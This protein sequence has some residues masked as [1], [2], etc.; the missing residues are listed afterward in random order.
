MA[1]AV[2]LDRA[3]IPAMTP[4][5][6]TAAQRVVEGGKLWVTGIP[7]L[8][9]EFSG[10]AGGM[11]MIHPLGGATPAAK[12][13]VLDFPVSD[14]PQTPGEA[15]VIRFGA[16]NTDTRYIA[17]HADEAAISPSLADALSGWM[18][19]GELVAALT[20]LGK[21]PV[22]FETIGAY[23]GYARMA[24]YNHGETAF[25]DD[26][27]VPP[28]AAGTLANR[29]ADAVAAMLHRVEHEQRDNLDRAGVWAREAKAQ[30]KRLILYSMGHLFPDEIGKTAIGALFHSDGWNAGFHGPKPDDTYH[31]G[32][33]VVLI[34]YQQPP[35]DL[36][37]KARPAGA[38]V[39]YLALRGDRDF[40]RDPGTIWIDPMWDWPD[41]CVVI[42]GYDVP[43]LPASGIVNGAI[44][45]ELYR[46]TMTAP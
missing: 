24:R 15:L 43:I 31:E 11:M 22:I 16:G 20:R 17:N 38:R 5:A 4:L 18:F 28:V 25:H 7:A 27:T 33:F 37:R 19:T 35:D 41:A 1:H 30:G 32:D 39:V 40:L 21:M 6:E 46:L 26:M 44:A 36:L 9:S 8:V 29:Y 45:W 3:D 42:E 14:T 10:R 23:T 13:V 2:E 12:D 34:G